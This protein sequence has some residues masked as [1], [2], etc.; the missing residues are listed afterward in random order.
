M[1]ELFRRPTLV[2]LIAP[3][4]LPYPPRLVSKYLQGQI[5]RVAKLSRGVVG[6]AN[7]NCPINVNI[8]TVPAIFVGAAPTK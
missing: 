6:E 5:G 1:M 8:E 7:P 2:P 4:L 3:E